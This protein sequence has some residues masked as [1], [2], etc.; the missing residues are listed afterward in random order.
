MKIKILIHSFILLISLNAHAT[1]T[2]VDVLSADF[3]VEDNL[4]NKTLCLTVVRVPKSTRL[5]G[6]VETI[7][8]CFFAR[9]AKK[10]PSHKIKIDLKTLQKLEDFDLRQHLQTLDTQLQFYFSDGE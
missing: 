8:D 3:G 7:Q 2:E 9:Q 5:L 10:A 6:I 4:Q 1:L